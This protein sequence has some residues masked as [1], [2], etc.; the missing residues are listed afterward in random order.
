[1]HV[2]KPGVA[3]LAKLSAIV[4][5]AEEWLGDNRHEH[6]LLALKG[7]LSDAEVQEWLQGMTELALAPLKR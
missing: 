5:H 1:M 4:V 7:L 3:L 6:D 2:L